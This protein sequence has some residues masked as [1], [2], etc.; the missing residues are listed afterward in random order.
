MPLVI[1]YY[2]TINNICA[3]EFVL[4]S[5]AFLTV[6]TSAANVNCRLSDCHSAQNENRNDRSE[7]S[8]HVVVL[9]AVLVVIGRAAAVVDAMRG[10]KRVWLNV[11]ADGYIY[12]AIFAIC[13]IFATL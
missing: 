5:T 7:I 10:A 4:R 12:I 1:C 6:I 3:F 8:H 11:R 2:S 13:V 9:A